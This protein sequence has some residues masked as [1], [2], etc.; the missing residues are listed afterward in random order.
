MSK[1]KT[2]VSNFWAAVL[3]PL[4]LCLFLPL[5]QGEPCVDFQGPFGFWG[6][7]ALALV[8][9]QAVSLVPAFG[10]GCNAAVRCFRLEEGTPGAIAVGTVFGAT[11]LFLLIGLGEVILT[12]GVGVVDGSD[13]FGR[14]GSL[15][16][17]GW[18]FVVICGLLL[19]PVVEGL[20]KVCLQRRAR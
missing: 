4:M 5:L 1:R 15:I 17:G 2:L 6:Q 10:K 19:V 16:C 8:I 13:L 12:T 14:W 3:N 20:T 18:L 9:A 11:I 7:F